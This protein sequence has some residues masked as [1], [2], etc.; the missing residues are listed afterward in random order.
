MFDILMR[1]LWF[2]CAATVT[3]YVSYLGFGS[4]VS[5]DA[6]GAHTPLLI[7]DQLKPGLHQLTGIIMLPSPCDEL[8]VIPTEAY[9][10]VYE[11]K[12]TTWR[13]PAI[14]C[15][16]EVSPRSFH[17]LIFGPAAGVRFIATLDEREIPI[18]VYPET[19]LKEQL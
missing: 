6:S 13:D 2:A 14:A 5:A 15:K 12:F 3:A 11:L 7:R 4:I 16:N 10:Y 17:T 18:V 19:P 8:T 1:M 9:Q